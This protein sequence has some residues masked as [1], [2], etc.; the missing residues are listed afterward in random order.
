MPVTES[1]VDPP[2]RLV[3]TDAR[4]LLSWPPLMASVLVAVVEPAATPVSVR[5]PAVPVKL[6][7]VPPVVE[8]TTIWPEPGAPPTCCTSPSVP[9]VRLV[10]AVSTAPRALPTLLNVV[11]PI[12]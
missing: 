9:L 2:P 5:S 8:P 11:P 1:Y 7:E 12:V 4:P 6:T 10:T 3:A